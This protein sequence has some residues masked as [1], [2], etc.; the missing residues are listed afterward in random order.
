MPNFSNIDK[1]NCSEEETFPM[2]RAKRIAKI[3]SVFSSEGDY[4]L[5]FFPQKLSTTHTII[6]FLQSL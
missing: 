2:S 6:R 4:Q 5:N 1:M 3:G